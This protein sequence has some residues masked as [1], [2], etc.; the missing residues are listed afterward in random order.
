MQ[1][2]NKSA[3]TT[4]AL[5]AFKCLKT[6]VIRLQTF[7]TTFNLTSDLNQIFLSGPILELTSIQLLDTM[8]HNINEKC[9]L[10]LLN[11]SI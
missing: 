8:H 5:S 10:F 4:I 2:Y 7:Q 1:K 9:A 11:T 6:F 3:L